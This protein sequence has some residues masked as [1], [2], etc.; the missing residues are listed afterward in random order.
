MALILSDDKNL[1]KTAE[2]TLNKAKIYRVRNT[3]W[4]CECCGIHYIFK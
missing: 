4:F 3:S 1:V 2:D